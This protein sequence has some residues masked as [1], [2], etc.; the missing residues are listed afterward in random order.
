MN[1]P[2]YYIIGFDNIVGTTDERLACDDSRYN[3]NNYFRT[4]KAAEKAAEQIREIFKNSKE[5]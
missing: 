1:K 3:A 5:E 4:R 2:Y